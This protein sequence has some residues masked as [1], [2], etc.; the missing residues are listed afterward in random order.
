MVHPVRKMKKKKNRVNP[1]L[2]ALLVAVLLAAAVF[3]DQAVADTIPL[4][5]SPALAQLLLVVFD[6]ALIIILLVLFSAFSYAQ[7]KRHIALLWVSIIFTTLLV[8]LL[9]LLVQ[10]SRP[11]GAAFLIPY[12]FPSLHA[13]IAFAAAF[14]LAKLRF[15]ALWFELAVLIALSR[16]YLSVH[17]LSDIVAGAALGLAIS[18]LV[19]R[20]WAD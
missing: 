9:K 2:I 10:R 4:L 15:P 7:H 5:Y 14:I 20:K 17:Y 3:F 18:W 19:W 8:L 1:G 11:A 6:L 12:A 16:V 13:A